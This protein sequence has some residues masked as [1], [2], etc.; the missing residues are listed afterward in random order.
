M[1]DKEEIMKD[2][3]SEGPVNTDLVLIEMLV[4][5]RDTLSRLAN[6]ISKK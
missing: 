5:I 2:V 6:I 1:R 3:A 4:D